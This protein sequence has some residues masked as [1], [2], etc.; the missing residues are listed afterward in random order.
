MATAREVKTEIRMGVATMRDVA[1]IEA[2]GAPDLPPS[3]YEAIRRGAAL[4]PEA[5]ALSFFP[6]ADDHRRPETW[7]YRALLDGITQTANLFHRLGAKEDTVIALALPNLP[8]T[9]LAIWGGEA[10]GVVLPLNPRLE[11]AALG[12]LL[13]TAGAEI[14]VTL[15]PQAGTDLWQRLPE[16]LARASSLRRLVLVADADRARGAARG[17]AAPGE[18]ALA[19]IPDGVPRGVAVHD[20]ASSIRL[21]DPSALASGRVTSPSDPSSW[22]ATGGTTGLPKLAMRTHGNEVAN[23]WSTAQALGDGLGPGKVVLCGLPLFHVNAVLVTGL[24]PFSRGAHVVLATP[25]GYRAAGLL[26][27][28]WEIV[29]HHRVNLFSAVPTVY[30]SLLQV[31]VGSNDV[32]TLD[33]GLCGA[34]PMPTEVFRAF[35]ERTGIKILEGYGLTEGTCVSSLN[36]PG[37]ERRV[38][39]IGLRLPGQAMKAVV[40]DAKGGFVRDCEVDEVGTIVV[41]G[42]NVFLGYRDPA[43]DRELWV[44][45]GDGRRWL[46][47]G[48]LG[49]QDAE[50][51][52]WLTGR[53]KELIIRGGHNIAPAAIEEPLHRHPAVAVAA[54]VGRPDAHAGELP[55]AYV[56][57]RPGAAVTEAELIAFLGREIGERA[58][59]P[60]RVHLVSGMPMTS[61]GKIFKPELKRREAQ[62]ALERALREAGVSYRTLEITQDGSRGMVAI[63]ETDEAWREAARQVLGRF[64]LPFTVR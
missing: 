31:P 43:Q 41:S 42:P 10:A 54:A 8:E 33:H 24:L 27:R 53:R 7:T 59:V 44:D 25:E 49:R 55:V 58:A 38:G 35:E 45:C 21:E 37:G 5:P 62:D 26:G 40:L 17:G 57:P 60:K 61:V 50:G 51:Y 52:F 11:G 32:R 3:T 28:F 23:A 56:Q 9:H 46:N 48:D 4:D 12:S 64:A 14:L 63:L 39:S 30:A 1:A 15:A 13:H 2:G 47:T 36:P 19:S 22:F 29:A 34:A 18:G 16:A 20:F 6:T